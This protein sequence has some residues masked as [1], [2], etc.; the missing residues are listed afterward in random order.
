MST[1]RPFQLTRE[2]LRFVTGGPN[3][4]SCVKKAFLLA[5]KFFGTTPYRLTVGVARPDEVEVIDAAGE[6]TLLDANFEVEF[7]ATPTV[8]STT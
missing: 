6:V 3:L 1:D 8:P 4:V 2:G 5:D 7:T